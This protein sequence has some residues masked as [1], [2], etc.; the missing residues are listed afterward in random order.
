MPK[1]DDL[2]FYTLAE[3]RNAK[4]EVIAPVRKRSARVLEVVTIEVQHRTKTP[5]KPD[6]YTTSQAPAVC[7]QVMLEPEDARMGA[8]REQVDDGFMLLT[9]VRVNLGVGSYTEE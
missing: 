5:G 3:V 6:V 1:I 9:G 2:G 7:I 8:T 4:G